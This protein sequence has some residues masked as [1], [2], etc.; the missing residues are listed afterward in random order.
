MAPGPGLTGEHHAVEHELAI[1]GLE[2]TGVEA[3]HRSIE[4]LRHL[5]HRRG[6]D[7]LPQDRKQRLAHFAGRQPEHEAGED[8]AVDL[9][10]PP[11]VGAQHRAGAEGPRARHAELDG[12]E[13]RQKT[14]SVAAVAAIRLAKLGQLIEMALDRHRHP[15]LEDRNQRGP[16]QRPVIVA[17]AKTVALHLLHDLKRM[18]YT[19]DRYSA[20]HWGCSFMR[21]SATRGVPPL[22]R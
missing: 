9:G 4:G 13:R 1:A 17:K 6:A 14:P 2:G 7:P 18:P 11:G 15:F 21:I 20:W 22:T 8:H 5:A 12:A 16:R 3:R 10:F 19:R